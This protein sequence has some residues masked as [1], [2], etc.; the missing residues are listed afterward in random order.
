MKRRG[1]QTVVFENAVGIRGRASVASRK[2]EKGPVGREFDR[3]IPDA[4]WGESTFEKADRKLF[5]ECAKSAAAA[6]GMDAAKAD[7]LV[8]GDL[9]NQI[10]SAGY[11]A[12][13]LGVPY[14]GIYGACS[15]IA[16]AMIIGSMIIDGGF[17]QNIICATSS[18]YAAAERQYRYPLEL[19]APQTPTSQNTVT[20]AGACLLSSEGESD[21]V[22]TAATVG[23]VADLGITDAN[24]MGAA[25]APAA[26]ETI[27]TH[28]DDLGIDVESV[29][30][31]VTGDL[32]TRG[33]E[34]MRELVRR[35]SGADVSAVHTD[36]GELVYRGVK[37]MNCGG[38]G[39]GCGAS[40]L[41]AHYLPMLERGEMQRILFVA[42][43]ALL[44]PMSVQQGESI[45]GVA[46]GV[47]IE[48]R[49]A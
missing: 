16:E 8:G 42:T 41:M 37:N 49:D 35:E 34:L 40:V 9:L 14:L 23:K 33:S 10:I 48:R 20:A 31:I 6:G 4:L 19:G 11:A 29:D 21:I 24:D 44:S 3:I 13:E 26:A 45:P 36:C 28:F 2:E 25:M 7:F 32:G 15:S 18:H 46:H 30:A 38:S 43:G 22:I 17:A 12:R 47:V 1:E 27:L 5:L 39:C